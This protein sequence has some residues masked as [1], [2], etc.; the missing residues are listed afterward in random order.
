MRAAL[1]PLLLLAACGGGGSDGPA[2]RDSGAAE[3]GGS[4]GSGSGGDDTG[5]GGP[6][7]CTQDANPAPLGPETCVDEAPCRWSGSQT[8]SY[9]AYALDGG[10]DLDGD[11]RE[12]LVVGAPTFDTA[13]HQDAGLARLISGAHLEDGLD[14]G[15]SFLGSADGDYAGTALA[16]LG[17]VDGDGVGDVVVGAR[18]A[19]DPTFLYGE[20]GSASLLL[21]ASEGFADTTWSPAASWYGERETSRTGTAVGAAG[22]VDGDGLADLLFGG[23]LRVTDEDGDEDYGPGRVYLVSGRSSGW[24]LGASAATADATFSGEGDSDAAGLAMAGADLD[25]DAYSDVIIGAPY[26]GSYR[27]RVYLYA[28]GPDTLQG[29]FDLAEAEVY[30]QGRA[31]YDTF[32]WSLAAGDVTGDGVAELAVGAPLND[33][34]A[35]SAG[36]VTLYDASDLS[37]GPSTL[38]TW[39][40]EA[41][42]HQLGMGL[43]MGRDLDGDGTG[44]L[45]MGAVSTWSGLVTKAG[46]T[47]VV[48]GGDTWPADPV[49]AAEAAVQVHGAATKDYLGRANTLADLD[50]DGQAD[51]IVGSGYTNDGGYDVGTVYLFFGG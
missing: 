17:D 20:A 46:T 4:G 29:A 47:Y 37:G 30:L 15:V 43:T 18:G 7:G 35:A 25:G 28:G 8:Y 45:V 40:G 9:F 1:P 38:A 13:A 16:V 51:L 48:P 50:G 11:G 39:N 36:A 6:Q 5:T 12:D 21:G 44:D 49:S 33:L 32:G 23:E 22:D 27:G 42:D 31:T 14:P 10:A 24:S 3:G 34:S 2:T 26:A 19:D 41:D